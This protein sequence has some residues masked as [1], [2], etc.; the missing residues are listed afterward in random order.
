M[1]MA[2]Q[3]MDILMFVALICCMFSSPLHFRNFSFRSA[4]GKVDSDSY[5]AFVRGKLCISNN[6]IKFVL[7]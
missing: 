7:F 2:V 3:T 6:L 4:P 5:F 1:Q